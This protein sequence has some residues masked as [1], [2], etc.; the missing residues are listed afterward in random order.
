MLR[1]KVRI[2]NLRNEKDLLVFKSFHN[3]YHRS[4]DVSLHL[5][6]SLD[7]K[8]YGAFIVLWC[9]TLENTLYRQIHVQDDC[10]GNGCEH[11]HD[12]SLPLSD[13]MVRPT[14]QIGCWTCFKPI[15]LKVSVVI[16]H[17]LS[18]LQGKGRPG[19]HQGPGLSR[20]ATEQNRQPRFDSPAVRNGAA[21]AQ[22]Q[23][24]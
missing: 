17:F 12:D 5:A 9:A 2:C 13:G 1:N 10:W 7:I 4:C 23:T 11:P 3:K 16:D 18:G 14:K 24:R 22:P 19:V 8:K 15:R 6:L 20:F 21:T